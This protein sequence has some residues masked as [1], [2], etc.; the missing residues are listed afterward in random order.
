MDYDHA[1]ISH[2]ERSPEAGSALVARSDGQEIHR[3]ANSEPESA[4]GRPLANGNGAL[5][6]DPQSWTYTG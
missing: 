6:A 5:V 3:D 4:L 2:T 1:D